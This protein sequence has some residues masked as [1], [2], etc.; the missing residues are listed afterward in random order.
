[1]KNEIT[2]GVNIEMTVTKKTADTALKLVE[3]Y[4]NNSGDHIG[5]MD[6]PDGSIELV[7]ESDEANRPTESTTE[8]AAAVEKDCFSCAYTGGVVYP[9][10]ECFNYSKFLPRD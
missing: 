2:V 9:C 1:M 3:I 10:S 6:K 4:L 7:Y 8:P 5:I